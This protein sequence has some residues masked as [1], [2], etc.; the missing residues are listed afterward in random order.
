K[1]TIDWLH[2]YRIASKQGGSDGKTFLAKFG[3]E[4]LNFVQQ[5]E[6]I[7]FYESI[8]FYQKGTLFKD[9][10]DPVLYAGGHAKVP[11]RITPWDGQ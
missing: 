3:R 4:A 9:K 1:R 7:H 11:I 6:A 10:G 2:Y 8:V 5:V